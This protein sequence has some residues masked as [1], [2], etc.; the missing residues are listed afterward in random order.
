M[1]SPMFHRGDHVGHVFVGRKDGGEEFTR[2][3]EETLVMFASQAALVIANARTHREE[4]R[5]RADLETLIDTSPVGVVV[6]DVR[7]GAPVYF[8]R[9]VL[10]IVNG[11]RDED[12]PPED[13]LKTVTCVRSD[14]R[15]V[16]I[17]EL[18]L[19]E[20]LMGGETV[21][22]EEIELRVPDGRSVSA[23]LNATPIRS[24]DGELASFV[25][26][27]QDM[28]PLEEQDRLRADFLAM[29]SHELRTP[30]A[31]VKGSITTLLESAD[32]LDPAEM[33]QFFNIIRDQS[34]QMRYLIGDLLD[35]ARIETGALPVNP[36][37]SDVHALVNEAGNRFQT[38]GRQKHAKHRSD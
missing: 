22:A 9:E 5:V 23:L 26:T 27:L 35:V 16:S 28:T 3:D 29:V 12:Q 21:R 37:P 1:A 11:L 24:E 33:N 7:T 20:A 17:K 38:G 8:N 25:V 15:E 14:G 4:R 30:L 2:A 13:L 31:A 36:E 10:R 18:P 19:A 32:E 34:D 6:L